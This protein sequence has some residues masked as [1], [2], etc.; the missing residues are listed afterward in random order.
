MDLAEDDVGVRLA[1]AV[2]RRRMDPQRRLADLAGQ[3]GLIHI[4]MEQR[5]HHLGMTVKEA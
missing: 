2:A 5:T 3:S 4:E 1:E